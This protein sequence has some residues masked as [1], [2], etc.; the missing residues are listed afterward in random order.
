MPKWH[1]SLKRQ[2]QSITPVENLDCI[3]E[4]ASCQQGWTL[5]LHIKKVTP[6]LATNGKTYYWLLVKDKAGNSMTIIVWD[7]LWD[8]AGGFR[9]G[10]MRELTVKVPREDY[11]AWSLF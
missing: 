3:P 9:E 8:E 6:Q 10:E 7:Y 1:E 11:T 4:D 2:K 5:L